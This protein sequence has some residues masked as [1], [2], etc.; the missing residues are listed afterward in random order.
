M[1]IFFITIVKDGMPFLSWH[2]PIFRQLSCDWTWNVVEGTAAPDECTSWVAPIEPGLSTDGTTELMRSLVC[3]DKR[4]RHFP[5]AWWHGK[6]A[7]LNTALE[8][9]QEPCLLWQVDSD[10]IWSLA[11]IE[12]VVALFRDQKR[13]K[14]VRNCARF[15]SRYFVG[16]DIVITS[17]ECYGNNSGYEWHRV[18]NVEPGVKFKTH[19]PPLL[20]KFG[21]IPFTQKE[22]EAAG[23]VFD[24]YAYATEAQVRFKERFYGSP[25]NKN[26]HLYHG[27]VNGWRKLQRNTRWPVKSLREFL[28]WVGSGVKAERI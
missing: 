8:W 23:C 18:W 11:Q 25:N 17:R 1:K 12:A 6:V 9:L 7:M 19:E 5:G 26:G 21:E 16:P 14:N 22:T 27:A 28:P 3:L 20:E 15:F 4:V 24:H 10:E 13:S 2:Y